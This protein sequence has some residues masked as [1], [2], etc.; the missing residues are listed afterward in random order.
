MQDAMTGGPST[1][2]RT[3]R[4]SER[5][6]LTF[7]ARRVEDGMTATV[8]VYRVDGHGQQRGEPIASTDV[9]LRAGQTEYVA[10][11]TLP[12]GGGGCCS[13]GH[14]SAGLRFGLK[15]GGTRNKTL[16]PLAR[17]LQPLQLCLQ[18]SP[19]LDW[20][21]VWENARI[22]LH[23]R[24]ADVYHKGHADAGG[25]VTFPQTLS[26]GELELTVR[27]PRHQH[28]GEAE[29]D[30]DPAS[31]MDAAIYA[32]AGDAVDDEV[33][34]LPGTSAVF[35]I[36]GPLRAP[37]SVKCLPPP[38]LVNLRHGPGETPEPDYRLND[39][40]LAYFRALGNAVVFIHGY[41][42][43]HGEPPR[44]ITA[45]NDEVDRES[46]VTLTQWSAE[47]DHVA[48]MVACDHA[49]L[50][51]AFPDFQQVVDFPQTV[52]LDAAL[53]P[54]RD[55]NGSGA[56]AW[57]LCMEYNLNRAAGLGGPDDADWRWEHYTRCIGVSWAGDHG[58]TAFTDSEI[59]AVQAGRRLIPLLRQLHDAGITVSVITHSLGAR[60]LLT[61]LNILANEESDAG[62]EN[63]I[64]WQ[65][66]VSMVALTPQ[67]DAE[68]WQQEWAERHERDPDDH[69]LT[70]DREALARR[71]PLG[72][73]VF[74]HAHRRAERFLVLHTDQDNTLSG[75][76]NGSFLNAIG[77]GDVVE[78]TG[79]LLGGW[80]S[81]A[82]AWVSSRPVFAPML[83]PY[84][85][86]L[87]DAPELR[88]P[89]WTSREQ[90]IHDL[91]AFLQTEPVRQAWQAVRDAAAQ[92]R[93]DALATEGDALPELD[94]LLPI[95]MDGRVPDEPRIE[96]FLRD[97]EALWAV[98]FN[99]LDYRA[100]AAFL[101]VTGT[102]VRSYPTLWGLL[103]GLVVGTVASLF[104]FRTHTLPE[105]LPA[106][107][108]D[109]PYF[110]TPMME[111]FRR[112]LKLRD[113]DQG[114]L[115]RTHSGMR[116][117]EGLIGSERNGETLFE[118]AYQYEIW[119][120]TLARHGG[121]GDWQT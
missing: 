94:L 32:V 13:G 96:R 10:P 1:L 98:R 26:G 105:R 90:H 93:R 110:G 27:L 119:D 67:T 64:L 31:W 59:H 65:P 80:F 30:D 12:E 40:E 115:L 77:S 20:S 63:A 69:G 104:Q 21:P 14:Q 55:L 5:R 48:R 42:V 22:T 72:T 45:L 87:L 109:G 81:N 95:A 18:T 114:T 107:G 66:A 54:G 61:A 49:A 68:K 50:A 8:S 53:D 38:A 84:L 106:M 28:A 74:G 2:E 36:D 88:R 79:G 47:Q 43:T 103:G 116:I 120:R 16:S 89:S 58:A 39:T 4:P 33:R 52:L 111:E 7:T 118:L 19:D 85:G 92:E 113:F 51:H 71:D 25:N 75:H 108:A 91:E 60:V 76:G 15:A 35:R 82:N 46:I 6:N 9:A 83:E 11:I 86:D 78:A 121:F 73:A 17:V 101:M 44:R 37:L 56:W 62:I 99:A 100:L 3:V 34:M 70:S 24:D 57:L 112:T 29:H 117:P 23:D 41:N 97:L 102:A